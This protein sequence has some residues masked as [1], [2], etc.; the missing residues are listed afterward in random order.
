MFDLALLE[1]LVIDRQHRA[2]RIAEN[3]LNAMIGQRADDH[4]RTGH[5]VGIMAALVTHGWLRMRLVGATWS[6]SFGNKKRAQEAPCAPPVCRMASAIPGG[7]RGY[8]RKD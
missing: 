2:A 3:V 1:N 5:L 7:A 6:F 4:C 8:D